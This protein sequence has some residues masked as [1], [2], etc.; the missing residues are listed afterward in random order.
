M[1]MSKLRDG[2]KA[3]RGHYWGS[4]VFDV[5]LMIL[6]FVLISTWQTRDLPNDEDTPALESVWLD[7]MKAEEVMVA[8]ETGVVYFFAPWC[9]YCR[10]SIDNLDELLASGEVSWARA[11]ALEYG[12]LDEV[13]EFIAETGVSMPVLL[14]STQTTKDWQV[15]AFPTY[16]VIDGDGQIVSRSV[17]YSTKVGMRARAWLNRD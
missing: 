14:G 9:F 17:G 1:T 11:V 8:G 7:D 10:H 3:L 13:R 5:A 2:W 6:A 12:S 4:L 16:F 15:R